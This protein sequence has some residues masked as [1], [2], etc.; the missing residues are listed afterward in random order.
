MKRLLPLLLVALAACGAPDASPE[1]A[2]QGLLASALG[3]EVLGTIE[4]TVDGRAMTWYVVSGRVRGAPYASA[5]W[6]RPDDDGVLIGI[7]GFDT[8]TP[9][10]D[11]FETGQGGGAVSYGDYSGPVFS[12]MLATGADPAPYRREFP[13]DDM[14]TY[15][16]LSEA[17]MADMTVMFMPE[18][19]V[20][21]VTALEISNGRVRAEGTFSG[22]LGNPG[23]EGS[24]VEVTNG[25]FSVRGV[26]HLDEISGG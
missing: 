21:D 22:R 6:Y 20:I 14:T 10:F 16:Y 25:R 4:A 8:Q 26:P 23:G 18:S 19:G 9:P 7:G 1:S 11:T 12:L 2:A 15:V 17:R 13:S 24:F 5:V 3:E